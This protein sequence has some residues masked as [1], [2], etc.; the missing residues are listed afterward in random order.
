MT[1]ALRVA[2]ITNSLSGGGAERAMNTLARELTKFNQFNVV[3]IPINSGPADLIDPK[4]KIIPVDRV[5]RGSYLNSVQAF[6]RFQRIL[7]MIKPHV[8]ILNCDLPE[9]FFSLSISNARIFVVEHSTKSWTNHPF[10][11]KLVWKILNWRTFAVVRVSNRIPVRSP[12][13]KRD[14]VI[15]NPLPQDIQVSEAHRVRSLEARL[16]FVGR[17]SEEKDPQMFCEIASS[18]ELRTMIIGEGVLKKQLQ[19]SYPQFL[20]TGQLANPWKHLAQGDLLVMTSSYEGDGLVLLEA[21]ANSH[22]VLVRDTTDFRSFNLPSDNYFDSVDQAIE[23]I[24]RWKLGTL[25]LSLEPRIVAEILHDRDPRILAQK[26][27]ELILSER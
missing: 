24:E 21:L 3:L 20:W 19:D 13:P 14:T 22:P 18:S 12:K 25:I 5:W 2:I 8:V 7:L 27:S 6:Y 1:K 4:C 26:W 15:F 17:I 9:M 23:K 11:G 10:L 16:C